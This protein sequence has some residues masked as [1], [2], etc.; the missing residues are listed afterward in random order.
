MQ[1]RRR[2][3][4]NTLTVTVPILLSLVGTLAKP[5]FADSLTVLGGPP[6]GNCTQTV[7]SGSASA[8]CSNPAYGDVATAS[9]NLAAG[10]F[11]VLTTVNPPNNL[12]GS[13]S[14]ALVTIAYNFA[15][16]GTQSGTADFNLSLSGLLNQTW[17]GCT[18]PKNECGFATAELGF[19]NSETLIAGGVPQPQA[20]FQLT[21]GTT[22]LTVE[23]SISNGLTQLFLSLEADADCGGNFNSCST[24]A[25][26]LD[27]AAITGAS[28]YDSNGNLVSG[29]SLLSDS[30]FN[31]NAG[32]AIPTPEPSSV[33]LVGAGLLGLIG[34]VRLKAFGA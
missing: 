29:A 3:Y 5:V 23:T 11:G 30:G 26:F 6:G 9:G 13:G 31:P 33:L 32:A 24:S 27:P 14:S 2:L 20:L 16:G 28:V 7:T 18:D 10:T 25:D 4:W 22:D 12:L 15:V 34:A 1:S 8:S 17:T 19:S 21:S